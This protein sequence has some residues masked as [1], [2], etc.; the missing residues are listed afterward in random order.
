MQFCTQFT[1]TE[2]AFDH[3]PSLIILNIHGCTQLDEQRVFKKLKARPEVFLRS[4]ECATKP[5]KYASDLKLPSCIGNACECQ[6]FDHLSSQQWH[7]QKKEEVAHHFFFANIF[8]FVN[9]HICE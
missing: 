9:T 1:I 6:E 3:M 4:L 7:E 5:V 8:C 2:D